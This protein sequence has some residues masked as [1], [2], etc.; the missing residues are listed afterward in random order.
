MR[1]MPPKLNAMM[2]IVTGSDD[3]N[4]APGMGAALS[5][6]HQPSICTGRGRSPAVVQ[7]YFFAQ[8]QTGVVAHIVDI[9]HR[10]PFNFEEENRRGLLPARLSCDRWRSAPLQGRQLSADDRRAPGNARG[11]TQSRSAIAFA[12]S[13]A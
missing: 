1:P 4:A 2:V 3:C 10:R 9:R 8:R 5:R 7:A 13:S 12:I 11:F 6:A